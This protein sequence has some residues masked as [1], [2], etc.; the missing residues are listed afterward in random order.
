MNNVINNVMN[1]MINNVINNTFD[2]D[3]KIS[4]SCSQRIMNLLKGHPELRSTKYTTIYSVADIYYED[5]D[6]LEYL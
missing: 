2:D 3:D 6:E 4:E 1:N 5:G